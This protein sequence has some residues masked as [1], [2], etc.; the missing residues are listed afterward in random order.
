MT[1][2]LLPALCATLLLAACGMR[3][4]QETAETPPPQLANNGTSGTDSSGVYRD[5]RRVRPEQCAPEHRQHGLLRHRQREPHRPSPSGPCR[6]K[7]PWLLQNRQR[8][9]TIEGHADERGTR[10]YNLALGERRAEAVVNYLSALGVD[11]ARLKE[12]LLRQGKTDL[13]RQRRILLEPEPPRRD[14]AGQLDG[15]Q[16]ASRPKL[17]SAWRWPPIGG[18]GRQ[19]CSDLWREF[20]LKIAL[21][22]PTD[23]LRRPK[24]IE[25]RIERIGGGDSAPQRQNRSGAKRQCRC[26]PLLPRA[27]ALSLASS[28]EDPASKRQQRRWHSGAER[29]PDRD[30]AL[31]RKTA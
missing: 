26:S 9:I 11:T 18:R 30:S 13:R 29:R 20:R 23:R 1:S 4:E 14:D 25:I 16:E 17:Q 7:R 24:R 10:E 6:S 28:Q 22:E 3:R 19:L 27:A 12:N 31:R 8:G 15:G 2:K 21:A 5:P